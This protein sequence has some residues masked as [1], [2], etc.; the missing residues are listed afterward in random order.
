[1]P[2]IDIKVKNKG[3]LEV[4]EGKKV[5]ELPL[6][7]FE[8]LVDRKGYDKIIKALNNLQVWNKNDDKE[9]S[10][11]AE[12][13]MEKL[14][15]KFR[16]ET[17]AKGKDLAPLPQSFEYDLNSLENYIQ[18]HI[19]TDYDY[20]L[21]EEP[22][23]AKGKEVYYFRP[24]DS[25]TPVGSYDVESG[26]FTFKSSFYKRYI[27]SFNKMN[28]KTQYLN[29]IFA[30]LKSLYS[31]VEYENKR[32]YPFIRIN[33]DSDHYI[34]ISILGDKLEIS[35][36]YY[37]GRGWD[38]K[39]KK[40]EKEADIDKILEIIK[41]FRPEEKLE[42]SNIETR[43]SS[44]SYDVTE[45]EVQ[46][47]WDE[48]FTK[49]KN[50]LIQEG[51]KLFEDFEVEEN[52]ELYDEPL[53]QT[54]NIYLTPEAKTK[55]GI[56]RFGLQNSIINGKR[57]IEDKTEFTEKVMI[58]RF[59]KFLKDKGYSATTENLYSPLVTDVQLVKGDIEFP[60]IPLSQKEANQMIEIQDFFN[61]FSIPIEYEGL[62][63]NIYKS[64]KPGISGY[65]KNSIIPLY[66][67][68]K[69]GNKYSVT[70]QAEGTLYENDNFSE[71][72]NSK[73]TTEE[74][75]NILKYW[76]KKLKTY[77]TSSIEEGISVL[78]NQLYD[79][80]KDYIE[81]PRNY[82]D[83]LEQDS[84]EKFRF[85]EVE[86]STK[87]DW[88]KSIYG[89]RWDLQR[90]GYTATI[91]A[92]KLDGY[93]VSIFNPEGKKIDYFTT[94]TKEEAMKEAE[95]TLEGLKDAIEA[96]GLKVKES[97]KNK[98]YIVYESIGNYSDKV[99]ESD[100]FYEVQDYLEDRWVKYCEDERVDLDDEKEREL[101]D[102]YFHIEEKEIENSMINNNY[103]LKIGDLVQ[104]KDSTSKELDDVF[105]IEGIQYDDEE[106][107]LYSLKNVDT[108]E[109]I[110]DL[111]YAF[112]LEKA[113]T[114][115]EWYI[116]DKDG[117]RVSHYYK[118]K[119]DAEKT[120]EQ[121]NK[122]GSNPPY[123]VTCEAECSSKVARALNKLSAKENYYF[124]D[125]VEEGEIK[126]YPE[127]E[128]IR[129]YQDLIYEHNKDLEEDRFREPETI[130]DVEKLAKELGHVFKPSK[131]NKLSSKLKAKIK[132]SATEALNK[133][134]E[135][136]KVRK[137]LDAIFPA[138]DLEM[139][140]PE[141]TVFK[142]EVIKENLDK[143]KKHEY[144]AQSSKVA[145]ALKKVKK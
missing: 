63:G 136:S 85:G 102:S 24:G 89:Q 43:T 2:K 126:V 76:N 112:E 23:L 27:D 56:I 125:V 57:Y 117:E 96:H 107:P 124:S 122:E 84:T 1:M 138:C 111:H 83:F 45:Q 95:D 50:I 4:P 137:A 69:T 65:L 135:K 103:E 133:T 41:S 47:L 37:N 98:H 115:Y 94:V 59:L 93:S 13:T 78:Y 97:T 11:W 79:N 114:E 48:F 53:C 67:V 66:L 104:I 16:P 141:K 10:K 30:E 49:N 70:L 58:P 81:L 38:T 87:E 64:M 6:K 60:E 62:I 121:W 12:N 109:E 14:K 35:Y 139:R 26:T 74:A 17:S 54:I 32:S 132:T 20:Y 28:Y 108:E 34:T 86:G 118:S 9:L 130:K 144:L 134:P 127:K 113:S 88:K 29:P 52:E 80:L 42:T 99:F 18:E 92:R 61:K 7:H 72:I 140:F 46:S 31:N 116:E 8:D 143:N 82:E 75:K 44:T 119:G 39:N 128:L 101:F 22:S 19:I 100:D 40:L 131:L 145:K 68:I 15:K 25:E 110:E 105:E 123:D 5:N 91:N 3:L 77:M 106:R 90:Y 129:I 21:D 36:S 142:D 33:Q 73:F 51:K 55:V 71:I 120:L